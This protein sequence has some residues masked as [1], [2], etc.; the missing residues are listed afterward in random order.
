MKN[1]T[2]EERR[3]IALKA[4]ATRRQNKQHAD[5]LRANAIVYRDGLYN[6]I[7]ILEENLE[8]LQRMEL[9]NKT[10]SALTNKTLL[11]EQEIVDSAANWKKAVGV[12]FL[13]KA[14]RVVYVGQSADIY[15]RIGQHQDK[16]FDRFA[17]VPCGQALLDKLESL[18]IHLFRPA[19]NGNI[20]ET[21][22]HAPFSLDKLLESDAP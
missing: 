3:A 8:R 16:D 21:R 17:F 6:N 19:Y 10:S 22:K 20:S 12:Y 2:A 14:D 11:S 15:S 18:Y 13:V 1:K 7:R 5:Q 4:H 9:F